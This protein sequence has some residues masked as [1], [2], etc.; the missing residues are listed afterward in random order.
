MGIV[1]TELNEVIRQ[2]LH[3]LVDPE[4]MP[5]YFLVFL[6]LLEVQRVKTLGNTVVFAFS[7]FCSHYR[8]GPSRTYLHNK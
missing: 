5:E 4:P 8:E 6:V 2:G 1:E 7:L 3:L